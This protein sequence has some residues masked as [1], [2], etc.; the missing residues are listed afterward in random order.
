[1]ACVIECPFVVGNLVGTIGVN[2]GEAEC[3]YREGSLWEPYA[4]GGRFCGIASPE[5]PRRAVA[6]GVGEASRSGV[7]SPFQP[8][9]GFAVIVSPI[10]VAVNKFYSRAC[11]RE[12]RS[13]I[14]NGSYGDEV[15]SILC[16]DREADN[17]I[18]ALCVVP[19]LSI[20]AHK[21]TDN[22]SIGIVSTPE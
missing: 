19:L 3:G 17:S 21:E 14:V 4:A 10:T 12:A 16:T 5:E 15:E 2:S 20:E 6:D 13:R 1:M 18:A 11:S 8:Y 22:E 9:K 7:Y